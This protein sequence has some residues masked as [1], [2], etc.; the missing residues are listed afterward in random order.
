MCM[1][2]VYIHF[3]FVNK[4]CISVF[5]SRF[6]RFTHNQYFLS[7]FRKTKNTKEDVEVSVI[8][9]NTN[10]AFEAEKN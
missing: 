3:S 5:C 8:S 4:L 9:G 10:P 2:A 6:K 1:L 7:L